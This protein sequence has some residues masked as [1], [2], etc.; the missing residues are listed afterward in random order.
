MHDGCSLT[1]VRLGTEETLEVFLDLCGYSAHCTLLA[2]AILA[3]NAF[4][5][6]LERLKD[7]RNIRFLKGLILISGH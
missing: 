4:G 2:G 5:F 3:R 6:V 7:I 1:T